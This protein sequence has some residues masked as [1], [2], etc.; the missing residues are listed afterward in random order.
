LRCYCWCSQRKSTLAPDV[1]S[2]HA[3]FAAESTSVEVLSPTGKLVKVMFPRPIICHHLALD[4]RKQLL[5]QFNLATADSKQYSLLD[6]LDV[7]HDDMQRRHVISRIPSLVSVVINVS[8]WKNLSL[9]L[10]ILINWLILFGYGVSTPVSPRCHSPCVSQ[11]LPLDSLPRLQTETL[12]DA[13]LV[14]RTTLL[15]TVSFN[16]APIGN[17]HA[18]DAIST[19]GA[20]LTITASMLLIAVVVNT[21]PLIIH[22]RWRRRA[23]WVR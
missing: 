8:L 20:F 17:M 23:L 4:T 11:C 19:F 7:A 22:E 15:D 18:K 2:A 3:F 16:N 6:Q 1:T 21:Y 13:G 9:F 5:S 10:A 14:S 12:S